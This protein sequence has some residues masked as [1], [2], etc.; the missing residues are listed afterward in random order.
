MQ[1][2]N[3]ACPE[4]VI[5]V[6]IVVPCCFENPLKEHSIAFLSEVLKQEKNSLIP[7]SSVL[8][9]YHIATRYLRVP[10]ITAK[11]ILEG[12]LDS[13]SPALYPY[14]SVSTAIDALDYACTYNIE[15]WDGYL[16]SLARSQGA[17]VVYSLDREL[18]KVREIAV[19][20]PFPQ[21][22]IEQYHDFLNSRIK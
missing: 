17:T 6:S 12:I 7:V 20:N 14:I 10:R 15:S 22:A 11:K 3:L 8:G 4:G 2:E 1:E 18:S 9:A 13:G 16:I 5:D 21:K 19:V